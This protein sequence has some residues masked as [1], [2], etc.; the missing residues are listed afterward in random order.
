MDTLDKWNSLKTYWRYFWKMCSLT[1]IYVLELDNYGFEIKHLRNVSYNQSMFSNVFTFSLTMAYRYRPDNCR[2][3]SVCTNYEYVF[4]VFYEIYECRIWI[5]S[6]TILCVIYLDL[7]WVVRDVRCK[8][9][10]IVKQ[11]LC[12]ILYSIA[13]AIRHAYK[14]WRTHRVSTTSHAVYQL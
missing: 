4:I 1:L 7:K 10:I 14:I 11:D 12:S 3:R 2:K 6:N 9:F 13:P 5:C 8:C